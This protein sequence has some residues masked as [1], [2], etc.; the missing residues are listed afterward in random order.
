MK[1]RRKYLRSASVGV[2][3]SLVKFETNID[4]GVVVQELASQDPVARHEACQVRT[5]VANGAGVI[6][7]S[8]VGVVA[9]SRRLLRSTDNQQLLMKEGEDR[10]ALST[11]S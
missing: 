4:D 1:G 9:N 6:Q 11:G 7:I 5:D 8:Q 3:A 10:S 2:P